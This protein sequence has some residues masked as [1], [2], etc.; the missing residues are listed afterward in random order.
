MAHFGIFASL[1]ALT[2]FGETAFAQPDLNSFLDKWVQA[3]QHR[4]VLAYRALI[5]PASKACLEGEN[6]DF[7]S[8]HIQSRLG[9][10]FQVA[11]QISLTLLGRNDLGYKESGVFSYAVRPT[12]VATINLGQRTIA[13]GIAGTKYQ[14]LEVLPCPNTNGLKQLRR[15][16]GLTDRFSPIAKVKYF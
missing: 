7:M 5:H 10:S 6:Q 12:H 9:T 15:Q 3:V 1:L 4:D 2:T 11:P 16:W 14:W 13:I 8:R